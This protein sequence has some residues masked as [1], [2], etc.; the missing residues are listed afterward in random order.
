MAI[1]GKQSD[2]IFRNICWTFTMTSC[3][4]TLK[5]STVKTA[6]F[7]EAWRPYFNAWRVF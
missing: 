1:E 2:R 5:V 7:C 3:C 6:I 4:K